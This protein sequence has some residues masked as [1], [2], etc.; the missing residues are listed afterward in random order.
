MLSAISFGVFWRFAPSM[1]LIMW[2]RNPS[3]GF[4]LTRT[5]S[6]SERM[7]VPPVTALRSPPD[8]RMTGALSPV[9]ALS[10][11]DAMPSTISPSTGIVSPAFT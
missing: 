7:T 4:A 9:I 11:T 6:Q 3:P 10:F 1:R 2:S 8:S 5:I